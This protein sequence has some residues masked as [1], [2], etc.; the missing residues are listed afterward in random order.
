MHRLE[1]LTARL[2]EVLALVVTGRLNRQIAGALG[3]TEKTI[4]VHHGRVMEKMRAGSLAE[5][6][7]QVHILNEFTDLPFWHR[8]PPFASLPSAELNFPSFDELVYYLRFGDGGGQ[9]QPA[10]H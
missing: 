2:R 5:L 6:G 7:T 4:K 3:T 8:T 1:T 10:L 9:I